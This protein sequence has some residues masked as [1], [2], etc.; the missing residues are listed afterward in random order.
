MPS[1]EP[2]PIV[3]D[4]S[5]LPPTGATIDR[6]ARWE[7][8]ARCHGRRILLRDGSADLERLISFAGLL[9]VLRIE[10]RREPEEREQ[11]LGAQEEGQLPDQPV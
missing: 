5:L 3:V 7:L 10:A 9:G 2:G 4:A 11:A 1:S 6:L 8:A